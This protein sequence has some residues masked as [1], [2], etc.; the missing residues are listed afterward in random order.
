MSALLHQGEG[1]INTLSKTISN[2]QEKLGI[3]F[4]TVPVVH[5]ACPEKDQDDLRETS[6]A[7]MWDISHYIL[8]HLSQPANPDREDVV[9]KLVNYKNSGVYLHRVP[10]EPP[11]PYAVD[12]NT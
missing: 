12:A 3:L 8:P 11:S 9:Q 5:P 2:A 1:N 7:I 6:L 4:D 10:S